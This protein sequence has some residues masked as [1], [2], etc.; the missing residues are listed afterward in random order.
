MLLH[1]ITFEQLSEAASET[2]KNTTGGFLTER[3]EEIMVRN[4]AMTTDLD[5]I[6][7]TVVAD[8]NDT[9]IHIR[10]VA[11]V[12][13]DIE[14]MRGDAAMGVA[15]REPDAEGN[16][17]HRGVVLSVRKSPGFDSLALTEKVEAALGE[18][19]KS[20]PE[21]AEL[22]ELYRQSDFI[23]LSINNL[24]EALRDGA[25]MVAIILFLFLL[26]VRITLITLTAIPLSLG[27][28]IL[29]FDL[30]RLSVNSMTLG[31]LAVAVGMVVD[32]AIVDVENVFRRLRENA[33]LTHPLPKLEVIARASSEVRASIL[34]ATILIILV[35]LPL[36]ALSGVEGRL[37]TP[38]AIAT[39]VS[40][41]ASFLVS[42]TVIPV[43]SS[44]LLNPKAGKEHKDF[45]LVRWL[46]TAF[47]V[48][49]M[50]FALAQ[51]LLVIAITGVL[52]WFSWIAYDSMGRNFLPAFREPTALIATTSAP[53][54]SLKTTTELAD[55]A[56][57][58][59]LQIPGIK[60]VGYQAGRAE[61]S[62]HV[63]PVSTVE[64][65]VEF[66]QGSGR[67]R[68][69]IL[70]DIR[71][72]M[73]G[74]PGTFSALSTPLADRVGHMLSGVSA[75]VAV[76]IFGPDLDELKRLGDE[77][78]ALARE[79]P[80]LEEARAEQQAP[81]P[82]LRIEPD[83]ERA[84]A[85]AV[86]PGSLNEEMSSLMGGEKV[87]E[88]YEG[89]RVYDLV[90]RLPPE[91]RENPER[92]ENLY[93]DTKSGRLVPLG[94]VANIR[95][96]TGPNNIL[97]ENSR[98]R[99]V[100]SINPT[101]PDLVSAVD[102]LKAS[103]EENLDL[104]EGYTISY[105]GEYQAQKEAARTI[106][107]MSVAI[108]LVVVFLLYSYFKSFSFVFLV[109]TI[110]PVSLIGAILYTQQTLDNVSIATLVGF[111]A[112]GGIAARN[113]IMLISHYLH[114]MKHE[115]EGFTPEMVI[116]GTEERLVPILMTALS[117]GFALIPLVLAAD[118]PGKEILNPV[119]IVI[120]GGLLSSTLLGLLVTPALF[121]R[122]CRKPAMR[123]LKID[124]AASI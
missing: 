25:I 14:P 21:G 24:K 117:A 107:I 120:V 51:P 43:L 81:V 10:D 19:N 103:I 44:M 33:S 62:D 7:N 96:A 49:W 53:G 68:D 9:V 30:M 76:K 32:D 34:Y 97:R 71:K 2:V 4:L 16:L 113:N 26:N 102:G 80:G 72:T 77:V 60:T 99:F 121:Y 65:G 55:A 78:T 3:A 54:T 15:G 31:G 22:I 67:E 70:A 115:G 39:I 92:L 20:L 89:V 109:L 84:A 87:A 46:K 58:Q 11:N 104:P 69:E 105:E 112:V 114:L 38:I 119:A 57:E 13:W 1:H 116:R 23:G 90:V 52:I 56:M 41:A 73:K 64:L 83:R 42:L 95:N 63:V 82:Q 98:R 47:R 94:T 8:R 122:F 91:W 37:F 118:E 74:V 27:I 35:F 61:R 36:M 101:V 59:L 66:D 29:V 88:I 86:T 28:A 5:E 108:I 18:L 48:T 124:S 85:Y 45:I 123:S 111:I 100:V 93:V 6:G 106:A 75:K 17:S 12:V 110:I 79:I 40:M 50:R